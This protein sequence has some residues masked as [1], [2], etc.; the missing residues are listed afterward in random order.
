MKYLRQETETELSVSQE[1]ERRLLDPELETKMKK[2]RIQFKM[3]LHENKL[4]QIWVVG[5]NNGQK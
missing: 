5:E 2:N 1:T 4:Q 3:N